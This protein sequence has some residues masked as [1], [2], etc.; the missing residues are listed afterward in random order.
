M[1]PRTANERGRRIGL[2]VAT[3]LVVLAQPSAAQSVRATVDATEVTLNDQVVLTVTIEGRHGSEPILPPLPDFEIIF[4]GQSSQ[5]RIV[6]GLTSSSIS[7]RYYLLPKRPG[8]F[9]IGPARAELDGVEYASRPFQLRVLEASA[10]PRQSREVFVTATVST[11]HPYVGQQVIYTWRFLRRVRVG[12]PRLES[13]SFDGFL[14]EDLGEVREYQTTVEGQVF[15]VSEIRRALFPQEVGAVTIPGSQLTCQLL[16]SDPRRRGSLFD[17]FFGRVD[18]RAKVLRSPPIEIEVRPLPPPPPA[19][20]G[21]VGRFDLQATVSK[22]EL[23]VGE[24]A[25]LS[26][27]IAGTGNPQM[28]GE[29]RL[30]ELPMFKIYDDKPSGVLDRNGPALSGSKTYRKALVPLQVGQLEVPAI[31]LVYFDPA[32]GQYRTART[33]PISFQVL[34]PDGEEELRLT[35]SLAPTTGKVAVRILADDILPI[36]KGLDALASGPESWRRALV[37][38]GVVVPPVSYLL[39]V[40]AARRRRRFEEDTAYRRRR[41]A[42][43][44]ARRGLKSL[45]TAEG[46]EAVEAASRCLREY[47]GDKLGCEGSALTA[48]ETE[49][50]LAAAGVDPELAARTGVALEEL[51]AIHYGADAVAV[52]GPGET[53]RELVRALE[54][55][56]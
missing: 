35:E 5:V 17:D 1:T 3:A 14:V 56:L 16:V 51:E 25:T 18:T 44:T 55:E 47:V 6:N 24:S 15:A 34:P 46:R 19:Y 30:P 33:P 48:E 9:V 40:F 12:D 11:L 32:P 20:S 38:A 7:Y 2:L 53:V 45:G 52:S 23:K 21:L 26:L 13:Q 4:R 27:R 36:H 42:H 22:R 54:K 28:I 10:Q 43:R 41:T 8:T 50:R 29:P 39:L 37:R 49:Q 31:E